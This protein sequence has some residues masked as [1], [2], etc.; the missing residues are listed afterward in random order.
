VT[1]RRPALSRAAAQSKKF[2]CI[3]NLGRPVTNM[4]VRTIRPAT[5]ETP[6][7]TRNPD[8]LEL[9][10]ETAMT[11]RSTAIAFASL[12]AIAAAPF[13]A[14]ADTMSMSAPMTQ[15][16]ALP[17][18]PGADTTQGQ[19]LRGQPY[20]ATTEWS[21]FKATPVM[22]TSQMSSSIYGSLSLPANLIFN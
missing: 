6:G 2:S 21:Q 17:G 19:E 20:P 7:N 9:P 15:T 10:K 22:K 5:T 16:Q 13:A 1:G 14:H 18:Q 11:L 4:K 8:N 3:R 12:L